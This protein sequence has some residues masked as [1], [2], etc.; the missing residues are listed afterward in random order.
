LPYVLADAN[1]RVERGRRNWEILMLAK[2]IGALALGSVLL[3]AA[4]GGASALNRHVRIHNDSSATIEKFYASN[5]GTTDYEE[6]ILGSDVINAGDTWNI[7]I[8]DGTGYCK[9]DFLAIFDDGS[10]AKKE[11]VNVCAVAD[12]YFN[13]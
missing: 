12:F 6:D 10:R 11:N 1:G 4:T 7:N 2:A 13:D 9:Y 8:D 5:V 3:L